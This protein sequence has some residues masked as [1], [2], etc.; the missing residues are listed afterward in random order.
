MT[1]NFD[2]NSEM[3]VCHEEDITRQTLELM[4][5]L[6][7]KEDIQLARIVYWMKLHQWQKWWGGSRV[8]T[9]NA[10]VNKND[11]INYI[12]QITHFL[13]SSS[14]SHLCHAGW[15]DWT[16]NSPLW[17]CWHVHLSIYQMKYHERRLARVKGISEIRKKYTL[18]NDIS[19][20]LSTN[21]ILLVNIKVSHQS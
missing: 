12:P 16:R 17:G 20:N 6:I 7:L 18:S 1:S 2:V 10:T 11:F 8:I 4:F 21:P 14:R 19:Q 13:L 5:Q 3:T 15:T 9:G